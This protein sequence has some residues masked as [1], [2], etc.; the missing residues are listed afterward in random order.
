MQPRN[1][2]FQLRVWDLFRIQLL[3]APLFLAR[4][5]ANANS[6]DF[7]RDQFARLAWFLVP[8]LLYVFLLVATKLRNSE[9][10]SY[11]ISGLRLGI[12]FGLLFCVLAWGPLACPTMVKGLDAFWGTIGIISRRGYP[13][14]SFAVVMA[15]SKETLGEI[16]FISAFVI[17]HYLILGAFSGIIAG[18]TMQYF[19]RRYPPPL[20]PKLG[21]TSG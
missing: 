10:P 6:P 5:Y 12:L 2:C 20:R 13:P 16:G 7:Q 1:R 19:A 14:M 4:V 18:A 9:C 3:I 15:V 17:F 8:P 21:R 11:V